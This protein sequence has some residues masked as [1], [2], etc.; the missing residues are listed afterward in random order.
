MKGKEARKFD[1]K[2][3][4]DWLTWLL[5]ERTVK[6]NMLTAISALVLIM[7]LLICGQRGH[8]TTQVAVAEPME[9]IMPPP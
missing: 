6:L 7:S 1:R 4:V 9:C 5:K 3:K 2:N 8:K